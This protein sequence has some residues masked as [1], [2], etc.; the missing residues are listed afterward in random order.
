MFGKKK[1]KE[2]K[3]FLKR[4]TVKDFDKLPETQKLLLRGTVYG[5]KTTLDNTAPIGF[6]IYLINEDKLM[7]FKNDFNTN[8]KDEHSKRY[9]EWMAYFELDY[10]LHRKKVQQMIRGIYEYTH[11]QLDYRNSR[12][13][14]EVS[15]K[16]K[17]TI[18][19]EEEIEK[20]K[21]V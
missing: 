16:Q 6:D 18:K 2:V 4:E 11:G 7:E 20:S 19:K 5:F 15:Y 3:E 21:I 14:N 8:D 12:M 17:S 10:N 9:K 1:K 13:K